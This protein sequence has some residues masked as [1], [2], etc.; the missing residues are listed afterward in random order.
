[1]NYAKA[2]KSCAIA[3]GA[4]AMATVAMAED[5]PIKVGVILPMSGGSAYVGEGIFTGVELAVKQVNEAGGVLG[6]PLEILLRD[7]QLRP[8]VSTAAMREL[9]TLEGVQHFIGPA[10]SATS[11]ANSQI[12]REEKVVNISPSAKTE[13]L[14]AGE[15]LHDYI[16]Q[17]AP[18]TD[19]DG[20]RTVEVLKGIGTESICFTGF[21]Y[22]YTHD[23][24]AAVR[25]NMGDIREAGAFLVPMNATDFSATITQLLSADC[26]TVIGTQFG[27]SFIAFIKQATPF[28]LFDS[29]TVLWGS[30]TGDHAVAAALG[31]ELPAGLWASAADVWYYEGLESHAAYQE[32]LADFQGRKETDMWPITGYNA[33]KFLAAAIDTAGTT[34]PTEVAAALDGLTIQTP[35]G[36][37]TIDPETNRANSPE[38]YGRFEPQDGSNAARMTDLRLVR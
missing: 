11:L 5:G 2:M 22:A 34:D 38:F 24:F 1:M 13:A 26:D 9:I 23:W 20:V 25:A 17:L 18:T 28:G 4:A 37:I 27:G 32:A 29:K 3:L 31:A 10:T 19:V 35:L 6:R 12:A 33:V 30:N 15:N 8:D 36:E 21:D 7:E 14:T 16:F